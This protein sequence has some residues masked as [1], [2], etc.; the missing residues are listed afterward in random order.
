MACIEAII[1][2]NRIERAFEVKDGVN[3]HEKEGTTNEI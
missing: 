3:S 2:K 1:L